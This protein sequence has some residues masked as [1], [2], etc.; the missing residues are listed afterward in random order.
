MA[1]NIALTLTIDGVEQ[2][3]S[4]IGQLE[5]AIKQAKTQLSGLEIG[6][7]EFQKLQ[8]QI[9]QADGA[10]KNLQER[11]E[12]KKIEETIGRY[13][14]IGSAI[15]GSFAAAQAAFALFGSESENISKAAAQAQ[16]LLTIALVG[17]E[18]AEGSVA[19]ATLIADL[20]TKAQTAST[21]AADSATKRFYATLAANPYTA[22]LIG[23]GLLIAAIVTLTSRTDDA[24]KKQIELQKAV[25]ES[26]S[27]E[28]AKLK[29]LKETLESETAT[30]EQ[31]KQAIEDAKK[32]FGPYLETLD[33]EKLLT[34]EITIEY[35]KLTDALIRKA[36][37][38]AFSGEIAK[39]AL[40][41]LELKRQLT[42][43]TNDQ[44]KA[45][46]NL[47]DAETISRGVTGGGS[48]P[49]IGGASATGITQRQRVISLDKEVNTLQTQLNQNLK[50]QKL[51]T[52]EVTKANEANF[53]ILGSGTEKLEENTDAQKLY[54]E[55]LQ[56]RLNAQI[57]FV[58]GLE[59]LNEVD[60][61]VSA[62]V[63]DRANKL[64]ADA[65][66][67]IDKRNEFFKSEGETLS[68]EINELLFKV[69]P[70]AEQ[71]KTIQDGYLAA[72]N[73]IG[74]AIKN[75]SVKLLD[76][77]GKALDFGITSIQEK[78][79]GL[80]IPKELIEALT[81]ATP[82]AQTALVEYYTRL[83]ATAERLTK[84][85]NIAGQII[86]FDKTT[87][88]K[89][90]GELIT[91]TQ[92]ILQDPSILKGLKDSEIQKVITSLF[93]IPEKTLADFGGNT[94]EAKI[95]L[96]AYN[97]GVKALRASL[98][99][100]GKV[101]ATQAIDSKKVG[102]ELA[103]VNAE[104][105]KARE[106]LGI[107]NEVSDI[108]GGAQGPKNLTLSL[109][110]QIKFIDFLIEKLKTTPAALDD[111]LNDV[112]QNYQK[113]V[114]RFGKEGL[115]LLLVKVAEGFENLDNY[116]S[117]QLNDLLITLSN[118]A[119]E[120]STQ[121]GDEVAGSFEAL[122]ERIK[123][124]LKQI[125]T[126]SET[127]FKE[128][129]EKI[130][131]AI[132]TFQAIITSIQQTTADYYAFQLDRIDKQNES[133]QSK[134]VGDTE[135]ANKKRI[136]LE[137]IYQNKRK[138]L[139]K[140]QTKT[141]LGLQLVQGVSNTALAIIRALAEAGP[142]AGPILAGIIGSIGA[143]QVGII[144]AQ[145]AQ[146]DQFKRGGMLAMGGMVNG[147][148]HEYGGVKFQGGGF[149]LE[150]NEA[151]INRRSS[152]NYM[153]LLSQINQSGGGVPIYNNFDDSRIVEAIYK[154]RNEP[155]R[156]FVVESDITNK[157]QITRRLEQLSQ[158]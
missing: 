152:L 145:L 109:E 125:P 8:T 75:G 5:E 113:Y 93:S 9:R 49:G 10:L 42:K 154:Q 89:N 18:V 105:R 1:R 156:A 60:G 115:E 40:K 155:I 20:A 138:E 124:A 44:A 22:L 130:G 117:E 114:N 111:V 6:S 86:K 52:D 38:E 25:D 50:E 157:Q 71:L 119:K 131:K 29:I 142:I 92:R 48:A 128:S 3:I 14:K 90:L 83:A 102:D 33:Q 65:Q 64:L 141:A 139:E 147:P 31:K 137:E 84:G 99:E 82:E 53:N 26:A 19:A 144:G 74:N 28:I 78:L 98:V 94:E 67:L 135:Q 126:E 88:E 61:R 58:K 39:L 158:F 127:A 151:V 108:A 43:A 66:A 36:K 27:K 80:N 143:V 51:L 69:I 146:V 59:K 17:R 23:V 150:G 34:G 122:L 62:D 129:L 24:K 85:F 101:Q 87:I 30:R 68:E 72:F 76:E 63:I 12:G 106:E 45:Q 136:E 4:T 118:N 97:E 112:S 79:K 47:R 104:L 132:Q 107:L 2:T 35:D 148:S 21:I 123:K 13:A 116:T 41:E 37:A 11:T 140:K 56:Q 149:E 121:Y 100:F 16:N 134:I 133:L 57:E 110:E 54:I 96:E 95:K 70:S 73:S 91:E 7:K 103:K 153:G 46:Q 120:I 55:A 15:T 32:Q 77:Q 81:E